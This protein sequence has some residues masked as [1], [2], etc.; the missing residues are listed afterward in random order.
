MMNKE[1]VENHSLWK[2]P[3]KSLKFKHKT[4]SWFNVNYMNKTIRRGNEKVVQ[5]TNIRAR[6]VHIFPTLIQR[7]ILLNWFEICRQV[8]NL[9]VSYLKTN[10]MYNYFTLRKVMDKQINT[11][12][13]LV[14]S[15]EKYKVPKHMRDNAIHDCLK[16]YDSSFG[17]IKSKHITHFKIR[18]KKKSHHLST[19]VIEPGMISKIKNAFC[20]TALGEMTSEEPLNCITMDSRLCY[21]SRTHIFCIKVPYTKVVD[22]ELRRNF[23]VSL[24]PGVRTFQTCY[25]P[26]GNC[27]DICSLKSGKQIKSIIKRIENVKKHSPKHKKFLARLREKLSN[28]IADLHWKTANYLCKKFSKIIIGNLSTK[29]IISKSNNL[30]KIVKKQCVALSHCLFKQRLQSK[31]DEYDCK[32]VVMDESYTSKTCGS[33]GDI[34]HSLGSSKSFK[35]SCGFK[36]DRDINGARNIMLKYLYSK[37]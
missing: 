29:G 33:C 10:K 2:P 5:T 28:K 30:P 20:P 32:V 16:A 21:N 6:T 25:T 17:L 11:K 37:Q 22:T 36:C 4:N 35:C 14:K 3:D 19:A 9:T 24:D 15:I 8:Y 18:Y 1:F 34:N 7:N 23:K 13:N 12:I 26:A 31:A 27:Y